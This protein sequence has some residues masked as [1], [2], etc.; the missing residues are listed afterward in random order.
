[1]DIIKNF[2]SRSSNDTIKSLIAENNIICE[3]CIEEKQLNKHIRYLQMCKIWSDNSYAT[4]LKVG[5]LLVK[6]GNIIS[7][8]YNGTPSGMPNITEDETGN[9]YWYTLHA[10]ANC[11][12][13]A[14][15]NGNRTDDSILYI[16][17]SPCKEC[18]KLIIQSGITAVIFSD[19]YRDLEGLDTLNKIGISLIYIKI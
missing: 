12:L 18:S 4:R 5:S 2:Y 16:T 9:T 14:A 6:N 19:F 8:G 17:S 7:D 3:N 10:E 11:I 1:M 15:K 13:K